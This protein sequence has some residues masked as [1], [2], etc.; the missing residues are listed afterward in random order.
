MALVIHCHA[1]QK[2]FTIPEKAKTRI[3][4]EQIT[5]EYFRKVCTNCAAETEYHINDVTAE[6]DKTPMLI[7]SIIGLVVMFGGLFFPRPFIA[8]GIGGAIMSAGWI[9]GNAPDG[10]NQ[11]RAPR[12]RDIERDRKI[13][14]EMKFR[15]GDTNFN[16]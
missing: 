13:R 11:Y 9:A 12:S 5:G 3:D 6:S 16:T 1:C 10:F 14:E 15:K 2:N 7:S 4:L 8:I